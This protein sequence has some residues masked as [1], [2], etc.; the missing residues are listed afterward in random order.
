MNQ[1]RLERIY[2]AMAFSAAIIGLGI[3]GMWDYEDAVDQD[4]EY[5][6]MVCAG[7]WPDYEDRKPDCP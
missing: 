2:T 3:A 5:R 4:A 1:A 7:Y 6:M